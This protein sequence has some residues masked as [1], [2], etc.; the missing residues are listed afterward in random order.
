MVSQLERGGNGLSEPQDLAL[1]ADG[2]FVYV[3]DQDGVLT[4]STGRKNSTGVGDAN[5][6][7]FP[8]RMPALHQNYP[9]PFN[10]ATRIT[11]DLPRPAQVK[12]AV[13]DM[14]G[15]EV[16]TL[17]D[18]VQGAGSHAQTWDGKDQHGAL[19]ASGIYFYHLRSP[20]GTLVRKM[21][22]AR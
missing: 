20:D 16:R 2:A 1:S 3:A 5:A 7:S 14:L 22:L 17:V 15:H 8:P 13:C 11:Y 10:P 6:N 19:L 9:N 18:E 21:I 4:F 12:L